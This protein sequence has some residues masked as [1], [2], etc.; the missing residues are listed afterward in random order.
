MYVKS[1]LRNLAFLATLVAFCACSKQTVISSVNVSHTEINNTNTTADSSVLI[2]IAP[3][4]QKMESEMNEVVGVTSMPMVKAE[5]EGSLGNFVADLTLKKTNEKYS[6]ADGAKADVCLLNNGGLRTSLPMGEI[7]RGKVYELMPF[8]NRIVVLTL[9]GEKMQQLI[10]Y[11]A[12]SGGAPVSGVKMGIKNK[13]PV[14][15]TINGQ[16][17]DA[18]RNYKVVTSDYLAAGGDKMRF[19]NDPIKIEDINYLLRDAII[20]YM[21]EEH[22]KGN[23]LSTEADGRIYNDK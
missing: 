8:D 4:K 6:P 3:Y 16:P 20:D 15:V 17:I 1:S 13:K 10:E 21:K 18:N 23:K 12:Y 19:F 22:K 5:P 9:T 14:N 7:T 11:L 2:R